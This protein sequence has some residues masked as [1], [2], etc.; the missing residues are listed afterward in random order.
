MALSALM[1]DAA[2]ALPALPEIPIIRYCSQRAD[3]VICAW[4]P[5]EANRGVHGSGTGQ[6]QL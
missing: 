4:F 6:I 5:G 2:L 3:V 1:R